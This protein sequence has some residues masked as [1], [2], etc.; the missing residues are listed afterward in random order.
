MTRPSRKTI[1]RITLFRSTSSV[2]VFP[3]WL[4]HWSR[5]GSDMLEKVPERG[6]ELLALQNLGRPPPGATWRSKDRGTF[7]ARG[8]R[9]DQFRVPRL[10]TPVRLLLDDGR[11]LDAGFFTAL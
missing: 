10:E 2:P 1:L 3:A 7:P 11:M 4:S 5:S 8:T 9:M 6:I